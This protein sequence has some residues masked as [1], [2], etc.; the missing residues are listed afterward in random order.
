MDREN[1]NIE[2]ATGKSTIDRNSVRAVAFNPELVSFPTV[3]GRRMLISF[4]DGS[5]LTANQIELKQGNILSLHA[6][7]GPRV[8][9]PLAAVD[10]I[11]FLGGR[12]VYLSDL[13]PAE[14]EHTPYLSG[15]WW[16]HV[17]RAIGGGPLVV[18]GREYLRGIAMHSN[19]RVTYRLGGE[20][21]R[22]LTKV[23]IDDATDGQGS[24]IFTV[25]VDGRRVFDSEVMRGGDP[26]IE[27]GVP[28]EDNQTL[29]LMVEFAERGD[30][31]DH[32]DWAGAVLIKR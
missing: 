24:V 9:V 17:D 23:G 27:F 20:Y 5:R 22:F 12:A 21:V 8:D 32:A 13:Q 1:L 15:D 26:P 29:T 7:C 30:I 3:E 11:L 6:A 14:Y 28:V 4:V 16:L 25:E 31:L 18:G 2:G 19:S 10:S